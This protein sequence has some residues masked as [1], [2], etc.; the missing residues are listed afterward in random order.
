MATKYGTDGAEYIQGGSA[1]DFLYGYA[2]NSPDTDTGGDSIVGQGG[3]DHIEGGGGDDVLQGGLGDDVLIGGPGA[4]RLYADTTSIATTAYGN[5]RLLGGA[6]DDFLTVMNGPGSRVDG[7]DGFDTAYFRRYYQQEGFTLDATDGVTVIGIEVLVVEAGQGRDRVTGGDEVDRFS[8]YD[9]NDVLSGGG[10]DDE[11]DGGDG[12]DVIRGGDGD[13]TIKTYAGLGDRVDGGAGFD[14]ATFYFFNEN[15]GFTFDANDGVSAVSI[16]DLTVLAGGGDDLLIG[17]ADTDRLSGR[18][19][20]DTLY[21]N[22]GDDSLA[23]ADGQD[24]M[25]GGVGNDELDGY[26]GDDAAYGGDGDDI[27]NGDAGDDLLFG[28]AGKDRISGGT[29]DD[30]VEGGEGN[31][32]LVGGTGDD[33][34]LGGDGRDA[35]KGGDGDDWLDVGTVT[36]DFVDGGLGQDTAVFDRSG[37]LVRFTLNVRTTAPFTGIETLIVRGGAGDDLLIGGDEVDLFHGGGSDDVIKGVVGD[38]RL[39]G[40]AGRDSLKGSGGND[41]FAF[42]AGQADGDLVEDFRGNGAAIGDMIEFS[43]FGTSAQGASF[44]QLDAQRWQV[45]SADGLQVETITFGNGAGIHASDV[46]FLA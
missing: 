2:R 41:T 19:G 34:L 42:A 3:A 32:I 44:R 29:D 33:S 43:G 25:H 1:G 4:D 40:G 13:D 28:G 45:T 31:D 14:R 18:G 16:E 8:G 17:D 35:L 46:L 20:D 6:G 10:G 12:R 30:T 26:D 15:A 27:I 24:V 11:L 9:G 21:G 36:G 5:D 37:E 7:G 38:D 39:D 23:G 22:A